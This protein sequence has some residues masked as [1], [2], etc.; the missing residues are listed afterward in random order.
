MK[1]D[2]AQEADLLEQV[3]EVM[4]P[5]P[6]QEREWLGQSN[7]IYGALVTIGVLIVQPFLTAP[8][9]DLAAMICVI[10]FA[11]AIPILAALILVNREETFRGRRTPSRLVAVGN[12][13]G[14]SA[15]FVGIVAAFWHITWVAGV[16]ILVSS[17]VAMGIHSAGW[18]RLAMPELA[19]S[20]SGE[21]K[22]EAG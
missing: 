2:P 11:V 21:E 1:R 15:A 20:Q 19:T 14:Q 9:L 10:S 16:V 3:A 4:H 5:D 17:L 8:S 12:G 18:F 13:V 7:L 22:S 6:S